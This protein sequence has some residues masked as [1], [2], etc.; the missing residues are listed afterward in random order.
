MN[1]KTYNLCL[2]IG[3]LL[4]TAGGV[5]LSPGWGLV[6]SGSVMLAVTL[7]SG[8]MAGVR[9]KADDQQGNR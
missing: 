8:L 2:L 7:F 3:W 9:A 6:A 4:I 5:I 1:L